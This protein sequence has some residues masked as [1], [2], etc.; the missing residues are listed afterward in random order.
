MTL[1]IFVPSSLDIRRE[2]GLL[3]ETKEDPSDEITAALSML[4]VPS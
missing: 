3:E 2:R 4:G 1:A